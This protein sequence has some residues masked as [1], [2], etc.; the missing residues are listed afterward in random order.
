MTERRFCSERGEGKWKHLEQLE[1]EQRRLLSQKTSPAERWDVGVNGG[2]HSFSTHG[3]E[4]L[5]APLRP[6]WRLGPSISQFSL[7]EARYDTA[8]GLRTD[9][10]DLMSV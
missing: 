3:N 10:E 7:T 1:A 6:A 4:L 8:E 5:S 2:R 9:K